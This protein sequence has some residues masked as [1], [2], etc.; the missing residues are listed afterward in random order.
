M[1]ENVID[2][3]AQSQHESK[4]RNTRVTVVTSGDG[5]VSESCCGSID[6][7]VLGIGLLRYTRS[8]GTSHSHVCVLYLTE[9]IVCVSDGNIYTSP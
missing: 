7:G 2:V 5:V 4:H 1:T 9:I 8:S 3:L 6:R